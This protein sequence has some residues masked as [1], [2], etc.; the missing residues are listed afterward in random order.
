MT[1]MLVVPA[2]P[3][4]VGIMTTQRSRKEGLEHRVTWQIL[5]LVLKLVV[6]EHKWRRWKARGLSLDR[7]AVS[8]SFGVNFLAPIGALLLAYV[9]PTRLLLAL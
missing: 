4:R 5:A 8:L 1:M 2:M 7:G 9:L 3:G 6:M